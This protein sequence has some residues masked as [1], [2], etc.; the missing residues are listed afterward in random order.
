M[1]ERSCLDAFLHGVGTRSP[2][3]QIIGMTIVDHSAWDNGRRHSTAALEE[4]LISVEEME[5]EITAA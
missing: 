2:P 4:S 5:R 1:H 3:A